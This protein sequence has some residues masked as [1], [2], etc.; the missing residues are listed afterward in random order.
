MGSL[1]SRGKFF[2]LE[3]YIINRLRIYAKLRLFQQLH[4]DTETDFYRASGA[5][6][7]ELCGLE[8]RKHPLD[9]ELAVNRLCNGELVHL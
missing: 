4:Q 9:E 6:L 5:C 7:C 3:M 2:M 8:Y 1:G